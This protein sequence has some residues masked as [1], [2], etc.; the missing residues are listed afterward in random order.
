VEECVALTQPKWET[1][2]LAAGISITI[3]LELE[4][5][6]TVFGVP[7]EI[8]EVMINLIV[9]DRRSAN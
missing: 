6:L 1:Q 4:E 2:A 9:S 5:G 7:A 3:R 8:R